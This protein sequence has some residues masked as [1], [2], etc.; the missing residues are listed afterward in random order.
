MKVYIKA[1]GV[2]PQS[3]TPYHYRILTETGIAD[4]LYERQ[5]YKDGEYEM[6]DEAWSEGSGWADLQCNKCNTIYRERCKPGMVVAC[7]VCNEPEI[8][9]DDAV[10]ESSNLLEETE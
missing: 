8:I 10:L 3:S 9:P 2:L 7:P 4:L 6:L 1:I 5:F